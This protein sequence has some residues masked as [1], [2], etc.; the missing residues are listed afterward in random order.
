MTKKKVI[1]KVFNVNILFKN[2]IEESFKLTDNDENV[3]NIMKTIKN[4]YIGNYAYCSLT[5]GGYLI[6]IRE[7]CYVGFV[8]LEE[9]KSN[10]A[11]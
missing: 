3:N 5:I 9:V 8:E 10:Y 11:V 6:D 7:T 2:G 1:E 4:Y